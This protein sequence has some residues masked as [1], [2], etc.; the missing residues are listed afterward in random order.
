VIKVGK[1]KYHL[2][3]LIKFGVLDHEKFIKALQLSK[4]IMAKKYKWL[5]TDSIYNVEGEFEYFYGNL[6]KYSPEGETFIIDE[7]TKETK[8]DITNNLAIASSPFVYIPE[9]SGIG[10]LK[11]WS[12]IDE[13]TF[14]GRIRDIVVNFYDGIFIDLTINDIDETFNFIQKLKELETITKI[15]CVIH[16]PNPLYGNIWKHLKDYLIKRNT[17]EL[18]IKEESRSLG[19]IDT[20]LNRSENSFSEDVSL[21]DAAIFMALDGYGK[22]V[23]RGTKSGKSVE[24]KTSSNVIKIEAEKSLSHDELAKLVYVALKNI[25]KER[26]LQH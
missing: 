25:N 14:K 26:G 19:G 3:R 2:G 1:G 17:K 5:I 4:G 9:F 24:L 18:T 11:V 21:T 12:Q 8:E 20:P 16:Q 10:Y 15:D 23:V 22:A 7:K 6:S 13:D